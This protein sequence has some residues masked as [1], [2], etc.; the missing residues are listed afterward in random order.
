MKWVGQP[1]IILSATNDHRQNRAAW[2][3]KPL[4]HE[5]WAASCNNVCYEFYAH[6][7]YLPDRLLPYGRW[8]EVFAKFESLSSFKRE[9]KTPISIK[10]A[11]FDKQIV[12]KIACTLNPQQPLSMNSRIPPLDFATPQSPSSSRRACKFN[13]SRNHHVN[14]PHEPSH[15]LPHP[16]ET[17]KTSGHVS[18]RKTNIEK[19]CKHWPHTFRQ[20]KILVY[21]RRE[22]KA[23][24]FREDDLSPPLKSQLCP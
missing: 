21:I 12:E 22:R 23:E 5:N 1:Q 6:R 10:S 20:A 7:N 14:L 9:M 16:V 2:L 17:K 24:L 4:P 18:V 11:V 3:D 8:M 13:K 19:H 15:L